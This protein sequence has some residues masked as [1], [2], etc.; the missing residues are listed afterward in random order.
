VF[1]HFKEDWPRFA[2]VLA[3]C[4]TLALFAAWWWGFPL[5]LMEALGAGGA[6]LWLQG[7]D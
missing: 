1:P 2:G 3:G 7:E 6:W 4:A 5:W